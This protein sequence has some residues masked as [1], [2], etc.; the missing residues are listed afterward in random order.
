MTVDSLVEAKDNLISLKPVRRTVNNASSL[1]ARMS[2]HNRPT[3]ERFYSV[4]CCY[5]ATS[6]CSLQVVPPLIK[7]A[8]LHDALPRPSGT[9]GAYQALL[10]RIQ[11]NAG[12]RDGEV[13]LV[14]GR[15]SADGGWEYG[16]V[17]FRYGGIPL[18]LQVMDVFGIDF[19]PL[20]R[21]GALVACRDLGYTAGV[22]AIAGPRSALPGPAGLTDFVSRILCQ[23]SEERLLECQVFGESDYVPDPLCFDREE[24]NTAL[25]CTSPSGVS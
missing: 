25:I 23:G 3:F 9:I 12:E 24:C 1:H 15:R 14:G 21:R 13:R 11:A 8:W 2:D 5:T 18:G 7:S 19:R 4:S 10:R 17:E 20:G 22:E 6:E 16:R